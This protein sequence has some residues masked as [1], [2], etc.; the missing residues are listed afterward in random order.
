MTRSDK[1]QNLGKST[2][3]TD[4]NK[5]ADVFLGLS[6][7]LAKN[8]TKAEYIS[9]AKYIGMILVGSILVKSQT[10]HD[11][12]NSDLSKIAKLVG[13]GLVIATACLFYRM[14]ETQGLLKEK[15]ARRGSDAEDG[16]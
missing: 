14:L 11:F 2:T 7:G 16:F 10:L 6:F 5:E 3:D 9:I 15:Y 12:L 13:L 1:A 8:P 4:S